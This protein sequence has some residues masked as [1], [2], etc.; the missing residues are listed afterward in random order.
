MN[1]TDLK[2]EY[3]RQHAK[4]QTLGVRYKAPG[5]RPQTRFA[6]GKVLNQSY[7]FSFNLDLPDI[8]PYVGNY[9]Q[10][11]QSFPTFTPTFWGNAPLTA[12]RKVSAGLCFGYAIVG[13]TVYCFYQ[14]LKS[15]PKLKQLDYNNE[16]MLRFRTNKREYFCPIKKN[17]TP[18][19]LTSDMIEYDKGFNTNFG[20]DPDAVVNYGNYLNTNSR[21]AGNTMKSLFSKFGSD[22]PW[23]AHRY[24]P[25]YPWFPSNSTDIPIAKV[26][27]FVGNASI[28][29]LRLTYTNTPVFSQVIDL[30]ASTPRIINVPDD[31]HEGTWE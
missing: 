20:G 8:A 25:S 30:H 31:D 12:A 2:K 11:G 28:C 14:D 23:Q 19:I 17:L 21:S 15:R 22:F 24:K 26:N 5:G 10:A 4:K 7:T 3:N 16:N 27:K 9:T 13:N 6:N 1:F 18:I 29:K